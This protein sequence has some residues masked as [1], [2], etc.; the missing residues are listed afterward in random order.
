MRAASSGRPSTH[1]DH[2]RPP[3]PPRSAISA[4]PPTIAATPSVA[5][6]PQMAPLLD[7]F[8]RPNLPN[9]AFTFPFSQPTRED[10]GLGRY[11]HTLS[12]ND[13]FYGRYAVDDTEQ[14]NPVA[15]P[16]FKFLRNSR[17]QHAVGSEIHV[18]SPAL[19]NT[20]RFSFSR[21]NALTGSLNRKGLDEAL[22]HD[23]QLL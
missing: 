20:A 11:D 8:P 4:T 14:T 3:V 13:T 5:V 10:Y 17:S 1:A 2:L 21:N 18:F 9:N 16:Q 6:A 23:G 22:E 7:L 12:S 15:Y 19:L